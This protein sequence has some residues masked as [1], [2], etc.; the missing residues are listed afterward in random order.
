MGFCRADGIFHGGWKTCSLPA[1][2]CPL[3]AAIYLLPLLLL[4]LLL[5]FLAP[6]NNF[7][8]RQ[9]KTNHKPSAFFSRT[10]CPKGTLVTTNSNSVVYS[11]AAEY[12]H[13]LFSSFAGLSLTG[14]V[15]LRGTS[16]RPN[17]QALS[18]SGPVFTP[19]LNLIPLPRLFPSPPHRPPFSF[20]YLSRH[21]AKI[22]W[23]K[24]KNSARAP[25][26]QPCVRPRDLSTWPQA[27]SQPTPRLHPPW[28]LPLRVRVSLLPVRIFRPSLLTF[29][30]L[31]IPAE[32]HSAFRSLL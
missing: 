18:P 8:G 1:A 31:Q 7:V 30:R 21:K 13:S 11:T 4:S 28:P 6:H 26:A 12:Q 10:T 29:Y 2:C 23:T 15:S 16:W 3:P 22:R 25:A 17:L 20:S 19:R 9:A 32:A 27:L 24:E 14:S 5:F